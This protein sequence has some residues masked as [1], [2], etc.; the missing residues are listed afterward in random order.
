MAI[1]INPAVPGKAVD[2]TDLLIDTPYSADI[3]EALGIFTPYYSSQKNVEIVRNTF[4]SHI[5]DDR[6]WDERDQTVAGA[7]RS[8]LVLKIPHT[9]VRDAIYPHDVDGVL[10]GDGID[11]LRLET[12]AEV[13]AEKMF[14]MRQAMADTLAAARWELLTEG[15]VRAPHGTMKT[16]YG[17]T[18]NFYTEFGITRR[19]TAVALTGNSDPRAQFQQILQLAR[20]AARGAGGQARRWVVLA[21]TEWFAALLN[22]PYIIESQR[23]LSPASLQSTS[24]LLGVLPSYP[25]LDTI[26]ATFPSITLFGITFIDA[27][28][29]GYTNNA[30]VFVPG[31]PTDE[32]IMMPLGINL[33]KTYYAP[34][35]RFS[36]I[37]RVSQGNYLFEKAS[38]EKIELLAE[39]NFLNALLAPNAVETLTLG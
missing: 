18:V 8:S 35:N 38:D 15:T 19:S 26:D 16:S 25:G 12:V 17:P 29:A 31:V 20:Q 33:A 4:Q 23:V 28:A 9:P 5:L 2:R 13:R 3:T 21:G 34:A 36:T 6:N 27:G 22:N 24:A 32:A 30:G 11:P 1:A 7:D 37:N 39:S 10:T 14:V